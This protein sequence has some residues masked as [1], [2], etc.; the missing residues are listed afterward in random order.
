LKADPARVGRQARA[1]ALVCMFLTG[2]S[3]IWSASEVLGLSQRWESA[4]G[5]GTADGEAAARLRELTR[6]AVEPDRQARTALLLVLAIAL[7]FTFV[8]AGRM[9]RPGT[10]PREGIRKLLSGAALVSAALRTVD[11]AQEAVISIRVARG[12]QKIGGL[13]GLDARATDAL[14]PWMAHLPQLALG[15]A[16]LRTVVVAGLLAIIGQYFRSRRAKA[17]AGLKDNQS[18]R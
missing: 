1:L 18:P 8:S 2:A 11:G 6:G 7:S 9:L 16:V 13:P 5:A 10:L 4:T 12:L 14:Q 3:G 17:W 15:G